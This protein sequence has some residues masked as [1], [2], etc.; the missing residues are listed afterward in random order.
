MTDGS[1]CFDLNIQNNIAAGC[2][3]AAWVVPGNDCDDTSSTRFKNDIGHSAKGAGAAVWPDKSSSGKNQVKCDESSHFKGYKTTLPCLAAFYG[4]DEIRAHDITCI[5]SE[6]GV[7][8]QTGGDGE[9][10][11]IQFYDS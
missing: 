5:D 6:K 9:K 1:P 11:I 7:S 10:K 2:K 4:T 8:L 3:F